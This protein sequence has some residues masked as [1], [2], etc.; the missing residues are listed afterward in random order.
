MSINP[1][2]PGKPTRALVAAARALRSAAGDAVEAS[3]VSRRQARKAFEAIRDDLVRQQLDTIPIAELKETTEGRVRF[4]QVEAAGYKTVGAALRAGHAGLQRI[5]NVGPQTAS[6]IIG[7]A[8]QLQ[9]ALKETVRVRIDTVGHPAMHADLLGALWAQ[10][11]AGQAIDPIRE[12]LGELILGLDRIVN[13]ADRASSRLRLVFTG[14]EKKQ[15][16]RNALAELDRLM[17]SGSTETLRPRLHEAL[18]TVEAPPPAAG[19]LWADYERRAVTYNGWLIE[20]GQYEPDPE[21]SQGFLPAEVAARVAEHPLD[22]SLLEVSLRGYQA[23]GARFALEQQKAMI[24]DEM[25]LGKTI[26]ALAAICHLRAAEGATHFLVVC[27]LSVLVNWIHEVQR[28]TQ[29]TAHRLHSDGLR[30]GLRTW[31]R[32]GGVGVTT[33]QE[34]EKVQVPDGVDL[35]MLVVDEAHYVKNATSNR[36][37]RVARWAG[38]T[39]RVLFLTGTPMEN[40]VG[41]FRT[42]V[43]YLQPDVAA[44]V[45]GIDGLAGAGRFRREVAS[46]YLR[47]NQ[48][49][50]LEELPP[51]IEHEEWVEMAGAD[52]DAYR[53]AVAARNFMA[54]RRAAYVPCD[55]PG[56]AKLARLVEIVEEAAA[57]DRKV[58]VFSYFLAVLDCVHRTVGERS[59]GVIKGAVP[60]PER[61]A[62]VDEFTARSGPAVLVSQFEA[63]GQGLNIQA[64]SVVILTEPQWKPTI[65][66][67]AIARCHRM[68]QVRPVDV[69]RILAD[70]SV[71]LRMLEILEGK[72]GLFDEYARPSDLKDVSADAI[73]DSDVTATKQAASRAEQE[74]RIIELERKRLGLDPAE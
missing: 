43:G 74:R 73:D 29:L 69:Y 6:K 66:E 34:L 12:P 10:H 61:Q 45:R 49:D 40:N 17:R 46:V 32:H 22:T 68:G 44:R 1:T 39:E 71:D 37:K 13:D 63:G 18:R 72:K 23:F 11:R 38:A 70:D 57:N 15:A 16:A 64:A 30:A 50:V 58:I 55:P 14:R 19:E 56:S 36:S 47:R 41:E 54:M 4:G 26:E 48:A 3:E 27:P 42:L 53:E 60:G 51:K 59:V 8:R 52:L 5:P 20:V 9:S 31:G 67:Q 24:G 7:A 21:R 62:L 25:G 28:H 2:P 33:Y 35:A 65:E